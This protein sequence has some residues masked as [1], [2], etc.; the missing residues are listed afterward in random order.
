MQAASETGAESTDWNDVVSRPLP[1]GVHPY[2]PAEVISSEFGRNYPVPSERAEPAQPNTGKPAFSTEN[3]QAIPVFQ[4][5]SKVAKVQIVVVNANNGGT[6]IGCG[7]VPGRV[8]VTLSVPTAL[9]DGSAPL[10]VIWGFSEDAVQQG[11]Q[12]GIL[13]PADSVTLTTEAP[14]Y[15]GLIPGNATGACQVIEEINPPAGAVQ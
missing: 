5:G 13:N 11:T 6:A 12:Y 7:R 15:L 4:R 2:D 9:A 8:S 3:W 10:G 14:I 1:P